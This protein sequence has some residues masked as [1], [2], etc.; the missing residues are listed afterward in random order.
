MTKQAE[1]IVNVLAEM[2]GEQQQIAP[3]ALAS[4]QALRAE[5]VP[6]LEERPAYAELWQDFQAQPQTQKPVLAGIVQV[7]IQ[8][9]PALEARLQALLQQYQAATQG[10]GQQI[11][12]DGGA[13]IGGNLD[14]GGGSFT[15][16]DSYHVEGVGN[17]IGDNVTNTVIQQQGADA[18]ALAQ[19][20]GEL[21]ARI[22][23]DQQL[24]EAEQAAAQKEIAALQRAATAQGEQ[25]TE[26]FIRTRL[27]NLQRMA[28]DILDVVLTT[29]ANPVAGAGMVIKKIAEK[30]KAEADE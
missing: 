29:F 28:P 30:M 8:T 11:N 19:A 10:T 26:G 18:A 3:Q 25:V 2:T 17:V 4:A 23:Q 15:G 27:Q 12:T 6:R 7:L 5:L 1:E 14:T 9:D 16:R 21:Y 24:S 22:R 20:F 13:Y